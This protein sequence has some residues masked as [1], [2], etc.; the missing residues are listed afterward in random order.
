MNPQAYL[1]AG[2]PVTWMTRLAAAR[3]WLGPVATFSHR[4]AGALLRLEGV[5]EGFVEAVSHAGRRSD[6]MIVH[7]LSPRDVPRTLH[8]D[9]FRI[10]NAE[11][12]V[13]DLF[14]VLPSRTVDLALD[15]ALRRGLTTVDRLWDLYGTLGRPGRNGS[16]SFKRSVLRRDASDGKLA[17]QMEA[18]LWAILHRVPPPK[19]TPQFP[20][21][22]NG[23]GFYLDF[24]Y[25]AVK[26][27]IEAHSIK[28]HLGHEKAK[29]DLER[30]RLLTG[31]GW[32]LLY[33]PF[34]DLRFRPHHVADEVLSVR[35]SLEP[36]LF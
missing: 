6:F 21:S 29:R 14:S 4:T 35:R 11:R 31:D 33:Y 17:S 26:L 10:T 32:T 23:R 5:P 25:P 20:V 16:R 22:V 30:D 15:D 27:G 12:T 34:D 7:R 19:A 9:G 3:A 8:V 18:M 2:A 1:V 36:R 24:A 13:F 28:W